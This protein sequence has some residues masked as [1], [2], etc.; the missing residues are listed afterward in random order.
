MSC[1]GCKH[2]WED[3]SVGDAECMD[4]MITEDE[5]DKYFVN[6]EEGCPYYE[7]E[8]YTAENDYFDYLQEVVK[9]N[10]KL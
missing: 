1:T 2:L 6:D 4:G 3:R 7:Q 8:D 9:R 10:D 5:L